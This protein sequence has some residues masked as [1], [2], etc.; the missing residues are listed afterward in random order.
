MEDD[1]PRS[2][3]EANPD[4]L[5]HPSESRTFLIADIRGYTRYTDEHGDEAAA[6][7]AA[8]FAE[9]ARRVAESRGGTL[10]EVRGD[11]ALTVFASARQALRA[12]VDIQ[13]RIAEEGLPRG[14]GIGLDS[15]EAVPV[16][17]G[18]RGAA[19][20]VA[21]RLCAQARAGEILASETAVRLAGRV[22]G[23][24]YSTPRRLRLKGVEQPVGVV[25]VLSDSAPP[26]SASGTVVASR[27]PGARRRRAAFAAGIA[28]LAIVVVAAILVGRT[29]PPSSPGPTTAGSGSAFPAG[30]AANASAST[31]A[32][33][34]VPALDVPTALGNNGRTG[35]MPGPGPDASSGELV[36]SMLFQARS[37]LSAA[38][39]VADEQVFVGDADGVLHVLDLATRSELWTYDAGSA[40][41]STPTIADGIVLVTTSWGEVH[42]VDRSSHARRWL[43]KGVAPTAVPAVDGDLVLVGLAAGSVT[44]RSASEGE[45]QWALEIDGD[46]S[47]IA[48]LPGTAYVASTGKALLTAVDVVSGTVRWSTQL[49]GPPLIPPAASGGTIVAVVGGAADRAEVTAVDAGTGRESWGW[50][51]PEPADVQTL[52][53]TNQYVYTS[54]QVDDATAI[55]AIERYSGELAWPRRLKGTSVGASAV[56]TVLYT[57]SVDGEIRAVEAKDASGIELWSAHLPGPPIGGPVVTGGL[58]LVAIGP[59]DAGS[60]GVW[61]IGAGTG[62]GSSNAPDPWQ[63]VADLTAGDGQRAL[64]L[65]VALDQAG[66]VYAADRL[67]HRVVMWDPSGKPESWGRFGSDPGEFDFGG[68]TRDDQSQSV[69]VGADGRIAVGDGGNHRV[70]VFDGRRRFLMAIGRNGRAPGQFVNPCCVAF[71]RDGR[72]FVA[73]PGRNDIQVF[74]A[75]GRFVR[76]IGGPGPGPGQFD[77]LGVPWVDPATG[78]IW[79]PDFANDRVQ[80]IDA[81][82]NFVT[83]YRAGRDGGRGFT[84]V[85]GVVLDAAGRLFVVDDGRNNLVWVLDSDGT[86]LETLGPT[87]AGHGT[88]SP[89]HLAMTADGRLYLADADG[90]RVVVMQMLPPIWPPP[91]G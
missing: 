31:G 32:V 65:N 49:D 34:H 36:P 85:N 87:V 19:L 47:M 40:I 86:V 25:E 88:I 14:A 45:E 1:R 29:A 16:E 3:A 44:A 8:R 33:G 64:Y 82:G 69:A 89:A 72:L 10:V 62:A 27:I 21:A 76:I 6:E 50:S 79:V 75:D 20:N 5:E 83:E 46:G 9:L 70:Q 22:G 7:L 24:R 54:A 15:G 58:V 55:W 60:G 78:L 68:V 30:S 84:G 38:P 71:D 43:V 59:S 90:S 13:A 2:P 51:P 53:V 74:D 17:G 18:F 66:N 91:S 77:R 52:I 57:A 23:I 39:A 81:D 48:L 26:Q 61:A 80:V 67:S 37:E 12:A 4:E 11:E 73:D 28:M 42:A 41:A 35:V 63:W 56:A